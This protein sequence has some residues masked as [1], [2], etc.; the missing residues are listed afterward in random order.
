MKIITVIFCMA[1]FISCAVN[2]ST[3]RNGQMPS[4]LTTKIKVISE[5]PDEGSP[6]SITRYRYNNQT[7]YYFVSACCDKYNIVYDSACNI[8][9]YPDG[10][11]T[12]KGDGKMLDFKK[13]ATDGELIWKK[14]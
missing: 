5:N 10:G 12:G 14:G 1:A 11:F 9:G 4:C 3:R 13:E 6:L 7:V 2:K 8:L